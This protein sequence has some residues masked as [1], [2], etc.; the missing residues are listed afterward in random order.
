M[1]SI[2]SLENKLKKEIEE[3]DIEKLVEDVKLTVYLHDRLVPIINE[4]VVA[5][6]SADNY[7]AAYKLIIDKLRAVHEKIVLEKSNA[8]NLLMTNVGKKNA[9]MTILPD[10]SAAAEE[11]REA[12]QK[13]RIETIAQKIQSGSLDPEKP[14]KVGERPE[15]L[16]NIR[17][18]KKVLSDLYDPNKGTAQAEED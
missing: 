8:G 17:G 7:E 15:S 12:I 4:V 9:L 11:H 5:S 3:V 18:A 10:V 2:I 16:K 13:S 6:S 14:R 1:S